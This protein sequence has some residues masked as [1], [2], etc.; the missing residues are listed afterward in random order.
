MKNI[1]IIMF[2]III[3]PLS[4]LNGTILLRSTFETWEGTLSETGWI[5]TIDGT[6]DIRKAVEEPNDD[7][8][9][10][11]HGAYS[12][13]VKDADDTSYACAKHKFPSFGMIPNHPEYMV[14]F[15]FWFPG[16]G[17]EIEN[18]YLYKPTKSSNPADIEIVLDSID[19]DT[20]GSD[21]FAYYLDDKFYIT[22]S[23]NDT[24]ISYT[25]TD[26]VLVLKAQSPQY[27]D[28]ALRWHKFQVHKLFNSDIIILYIDGDSIATFKSASG[29]SH[30]DTFLIGTTDT[31]QNGEG[32]WD[33]FIITTV[34][35]WNHPRLF[36]SQSDTAALRARA[37]TT[38][39]TILGWSYKDMA[40]TIIALADSCLSYGYFTYPFCYEYTMNLPFP[41]P[42]PSSKSKYTA[43]LS[44]NREIE[45]W[46]Q[47]LSFA[48]IIE[49]D[50]NYSDTTKSILMSLSN[51]WA[52]WTNMQFGPQTSG[53]HPYTSYD[54]AHLVAS[55]AIAYDMIFDRLNGYE[56]MTIQNS[57]LSLGIN[58]DHLIA[59]WLEEWDDNPV[60]QPNG[61]A[62]IFSAMGLASL[63]ID[64]ND[65]RNLC[66][67]IAK[68]R[69]KH[70]LDERKVCDSLGGWI[71]GITYSEYGTDYIVA[72]AE[73]EK[74]IQNDTILKG[75]PYPQNYPTFRTY[76][77]VFSA[78]RDS[79][80]EVNFE[81][82][83]D[84]ACYAN[85]G[86]MY[87]VTENSDSVGQW[88]LAHSR[89]KWPE[90]KNSGGY[91]CIDLIQRYFQFGPF[92]W[93]DSGLDTLH[94]D[95]I[96]LPLGRLM[97]DIGWGILRN[98]WDS[99]STVLAFKSD[100]CGN[101]CHPAQNRFIYG[102]KGKWFIEEMGYPPKEKKEP[103]WHNVILVNDTLNDAKKDGEIKRF[104]TSNDYSYIMGN[105]S[106]C[107]TR[108]DRWQREIVMVN[109]PGFIV[110]KDGIES[111]T[112]VMID[113]RI[114]SHIG[115]GEQMYDKDSVITIKK[116]GQY[117]YGKIIEPK[118]AE[119]D[120]FP[121]IGKPLNWYGMSIDSI[122]CNTKTTYIVP[123]FIG[124]TFPEI[125]K[126]PGS[127]VFATGVNYETSTDTTNGVV[128]FSKGCDD[129]KGLSYV[130]DVDSSDSI[131][132][133][134]L[135]DLYV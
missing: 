64:D 70:I 41:Q 95:S 135:A 106:L 65:V 1:V 99:T 68:A 8:Q 84:A 51:D 32:F 36:F 15:Y 90:W 132:F 55:V 78:D 79:N 87:L 96:P 53:A 57:L 83:N 38:D 75:R 6:G 113:W 67:S 22:V 10:Q 111:N 30:P 86:V 85:E 116:A 23:D 109:D 52:Q 9:T 66:D 81:D 133:N 45:A 3:V 14:E 73:A 82:Y 114:H 130:V 129:V 108:L 74:R 107:D 76:C 34:P 59:I 4:V 115:T 33:D 13:R 56:K 112:N 98:G 80:V 28:H 35:N 60:Y 42:E 118:E 19:I 104:Y 93:F 71:E 2:T 5:L 17:V 69:I 121:W 72:Y 101:H 58:Q 88:Y 43:W 44:I 134:V 62:V 122:D 123:F 102:S 49:N 20:T 24:S 26:S 126:L 46:L 124:D 131:V 48:Y 21:N 63:V 105:D 120:T 103:P 100:T 89:I 127:S 18:V 117:L 77:T 91:V 97:E 92:L 119:W 7:Y 39:T 29:T 47:V 12:I 25:Y 125:S 37:D 110:V 94:P 50:T 31:L 40:D 61:Y 16:S 27:H 11:L 128:V 54:A